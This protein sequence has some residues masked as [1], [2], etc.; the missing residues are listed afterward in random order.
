MMP[1]E[2]QTDFDGLI[3][4]SKL[5]PYLN[6]QV[7]IYCFTLGTEAKTAIKIKKG[8]NYVMKNEV[9]VGFGVCRNGILELNIHPISEKYVK[10]VNNSEGYQE[11]SSILSYYGAITSIDRTCFCLKNEEI[12]KL[13]LESWP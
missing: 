5:V 1:I 9:P 3:D 8:F 4:A 11:H 7:D 6:K 10:F 12:K 2:F 13:L